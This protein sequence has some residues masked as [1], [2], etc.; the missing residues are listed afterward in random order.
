MEIGRDLGN[1]NLLGIESSQPSN[2]LQFH[3]NLTRS[4]WFHF[5]RKIPLLEMHESIVAIG[6]AVQYFN[7]LFICTRLPSAFVYLISVRLFPG[8]TQLL[9]WP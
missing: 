1:F 8:T 3:C 4:Y 5:A 9:W 2:S 7:A 6:Y